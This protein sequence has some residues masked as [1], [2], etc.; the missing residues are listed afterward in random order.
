VAQ[1]LQVPENG[2]LVWC[3]ADSPEFNPVERLGEALQDWIDAVDGD[4]RS[5]LVA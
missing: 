5:S 1:R 4:V 3:R 2:V